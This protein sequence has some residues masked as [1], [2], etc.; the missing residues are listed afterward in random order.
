[1]DSLVNQVLSTLTSSQEFREIAQNVFEHP[2]RHEDF[3]EL[4]MPEGC[5][6]Q[7]LW[8]FM[9]MLEH[10]AGYTIPIKPWF[11]GVDRN[12]CWY[13]LNTASR[14]ELCEIAALAAPDSSLNKFIKTRATNDRRILGFVFEEIAS[15]ARY[16]GIAVTERIVADLWLKERKPQNASERIL[17]NASKAFMRANALTSSK[18]YS[19]ILVAD[20][21]DILLEGVNETALEL[22][23]RLHWNENLCDMSLLSD[24]A[25]GA[26]ALDWVTVR[27]Q[28]AADVQDVVTA[29]IAG[30]STLND[31]TYVTSL[32]NLTEFMLRRV[33]CLKHDMPVL[34]YVPFT[35]IS[36]V[37]FQ[38]FQQTHETD[39]ISAPQEGLS[40]TWIYAEHIKSYLEGLHAIEET[41]RSVEENDR[42]QRAAI[43]CIPEVTARQ[44]TFLMKAA[45]NPNRAFSIKQYAN[46]Y[47]IVYATAR[48]DLLDLSE[49][50]L[51]VMRKSGR[52][53]LFQT[54][55]NSH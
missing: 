36:D 47:G 35:S 46:T 43:A 16:D 22:S 25:Y 27:A 34:S 21:H 4:P 45:A 49:R 54:P 9:M 29:V 40:S 2:L 55:A 1:M 12:T 37:Y 39:S 30:N 53:F 51:L 6:S 28:H 13:Y 8:E 19:R 44:K 5:D 48:R 15:T 24:S 17:A 20:I 23:P 10:C 33:F 41:M 7:I 42:V 31:V 14:D 50:G 3:L 52:T 38:S 26:D 18:P 11:K 32:R